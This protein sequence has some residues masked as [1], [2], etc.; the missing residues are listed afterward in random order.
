MRILVA[1]I[2]MMTVSGCWRGASDVVDNRPICD[3]TE[4]QRTAH[5]AALAADGGPQS[6]VTGRALIAAV[7]AGCEG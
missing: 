5:A 4:A 6:V 2:L 3:G 7:D 1:V